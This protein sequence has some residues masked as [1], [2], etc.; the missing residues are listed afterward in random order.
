MIRSGILGGLFCALG[1]LVP[2]ALA[3]DGAVDLSMNCF[4]ES[5]QE[6]RRYE[7]IGDG[8]RSVNADV[9]GEPEPIH[10]S[11]DANLRYVVQFKTYSGMVDIEYDFDKLTVIKNLASGPQKLSCE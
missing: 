6:W 8:I 3:D 5:K 11:D 4:D 1:G 9:A 10:E 7:K 2:A